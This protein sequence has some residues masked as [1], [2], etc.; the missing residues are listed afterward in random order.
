MVHRNGSQRR[1]SASRVAL[2]SY[3]VIGKGLFLALCLE[4]LKSEDV[5]VS[6]PRLKFRNV[7]SSWSLARRPVD[8]AINRFNYE[9]GSGKT[10]TGGENEENES[11]MFCH[12]ERLCAE[13]VELR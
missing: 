12:D 8:T 6:L 1:F 5:E 9:Q 11:R 4:S 13:E 2:T 3:L 10:K 7:L